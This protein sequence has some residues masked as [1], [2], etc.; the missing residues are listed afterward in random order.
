MGDL[1]S[2]AQGCEDLGVVALTRSDLDRAAVSLKESIALSLEVGQS[3]LVASGLMGLGVV[4]AREQPMRAARHFGA[5]EALREVVG[6]TIWPPRRKLC[7]HALEAVRDALGAA[8]FAAAWAEGSAMTL[9]R[10]VEYALERDTTAPM[11]P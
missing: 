7:D 6:V 8:A 11:A 3:E 10:A 1:R 4:T 2:I 9:E 5:A